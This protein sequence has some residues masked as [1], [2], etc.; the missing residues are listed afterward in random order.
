MYSSVRNSYNKMLL[1]NDGKA[2]LKIES[3][4][5]VQNYVYAF[6][7]THSFLVDMTWNGSVNNR[8]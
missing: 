6:F 8:A 2:F 3:G 5:E 4:N 7:L 1:V